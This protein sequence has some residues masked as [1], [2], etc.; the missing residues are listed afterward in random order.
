MNRILKISLITGLLIAVLVLSAGCFGTSSTSVTS[1]NATGSADQP[2]TWE[3]MWPMLAFLVVIFAMFYFVMIRPQRK[4]QKQQ[5]ALMQGLQKGDKVITAGG[6]YGT[7][8]NVGDESI[9]IK[10]ES[11][12]TIRVNKGSVALRRDETKTK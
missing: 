11:G 7:I 12:T 10:I 2:S 9:V 3:S 1:T 6:I 5:E 8:E 4:R